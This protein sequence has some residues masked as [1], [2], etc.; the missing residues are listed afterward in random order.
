MPENTTEAI[1]P[2]TKFST[3]LHEFL[4]WVLFSLVLA[5][6]QLWLIP[7]G[8]Y[9]YD[10]PLKMVEVIGNGSLLFFATTT[11]SR[12]A[13]EYFKKVK[14]HHPTAKLICIAMLLLIIL[15]SVFAYALEIATRLGG[16]G[17]LALSAEK[18]TRLSLGLAAAGAIFSL[19]FTM[20]TK[21][22]G[23]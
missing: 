3:F 19:S 18:V 11:V 9:L 10:R 14:S 22:Y 21:A 6:A 23:D 13:G 4:Y 17:T 20:L 7:L 16:V 8:Y 15:P 12:S 1:Q 5:L 2:A